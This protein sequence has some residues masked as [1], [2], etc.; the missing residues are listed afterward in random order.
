IMGNLFK[1]LQRIFPVRDLS[2]LLPH[3]PA[4]R[5]VLSAFE[6]DILHQQDH[7]HSQEKRK[8]HHRLSVHIFCPLILFFS[9][10]KSP[11]FKVKRRQTEEN[12]PFSSVCRHRKSPL[13]P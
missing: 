13:P 5:S 7:R 1:F 11:L 12:A 10:I 6:K 4:H 2:P 9:S 3:L 8:I